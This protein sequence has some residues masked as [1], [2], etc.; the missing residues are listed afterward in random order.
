MEDKEKSESRRGNG[1]Y[2][3]TNV[4]SEERGDLKKQW[5][6]GHLNG[7]MLSKDLDGLKEPPTPGQLD[8][9]V[10]RR[11]TG[12]WAGCRDANRRD[13]GDEGTKGRGN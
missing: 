2:D 3:D 6:Y 9:V 5:W 4:A 1:L 8:R 7:E 11:L 10:K 13:L 12:K